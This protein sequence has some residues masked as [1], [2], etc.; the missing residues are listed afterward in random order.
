[1]P[2]CVVVCVSPGSPAASTAGQTACRGDGVE[3]GGSGVCRTQATCGPDV[4]EGENRL[5]LVC[6]CQPGLRG[7]TACRAAGPAVWRTHAA[8]GAE[9]VR[10]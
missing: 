10:R 9:C 1:M 3:G 5:S 7:Q 2:C 6:V 4:H 8:S